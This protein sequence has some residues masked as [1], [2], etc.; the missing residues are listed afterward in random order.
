MVVLVWCRSVG[1][2]FS[3]SCSVS[4]III[5]IIRGVS[6]V[7]SITAI[8]IMIM[9]SSTSSVSSGVVSIIW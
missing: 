1:I 9:I 5:G 3:V 2:T 4:I 8:R 6:S 7:S